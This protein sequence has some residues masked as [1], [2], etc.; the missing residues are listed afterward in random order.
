MGGLRGYGSRSDSLNSGP[1]HRGSRGERAVSVAATPSH[2]L[3][4][5]GPNRPR[6]DTAGS[7]PSGPRAGA[8]RVTQAGRASHDAE[9]QP[10]R[11]GPAPALRFG[12]AIH[13]HRDDDAPADPAQQHELTFI[14]RDQPGRTAVSATQ[15]PSTS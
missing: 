2:G 7:W 11:Q 5:N 3:S 13:P 4:A 1:A 6:P 9:R 8:V 12:S 10:A 15:S 14:R